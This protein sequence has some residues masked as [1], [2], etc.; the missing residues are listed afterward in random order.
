MKLKQK[1]KNN[2]KMLLKSKEL[3]TTKIKIGF[4]IK[5]K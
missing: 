1:K 4:K 2:K 3:Y 5:K